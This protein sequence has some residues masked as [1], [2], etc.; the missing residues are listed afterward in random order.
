MKCECEAT[1]GG[2]LVKVCKIHAAFT[3]EATKEAS[4][5]AWSGAIH[6]SAE[7]QDLVADLFS[8]KHK[9]AAN[10][11]VRLYREAL[12]KRSKV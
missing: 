5:Q 12:Q 11:G 4:S 3:D 8:E 7:V 1:P 9:V 6:I 10:I 2:K